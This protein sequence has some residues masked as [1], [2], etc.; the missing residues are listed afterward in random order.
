MNF[1]ETR[2]NTTGL[3]LMMCQFGDWNPIEVTP[4]H[5]TASLSYIHDVRRMSEL[6]SAIGNEEDATMWQR[7]SDFLTA[8]FHSSCRVVNNAC[9]HSQTDKTDETDEPYGGF[10]NGSHYSTGTQMST[11]AALW[12]GDMPDDGRKEELLK[13]LTADLSK[14]GLTGG[15]VFTQYMYEALVR[16][17]RTAAAVGLLLRTSFPGFGHEIYNIYEPGSTLW[18]SW[19]G[20]SMAQ[21]MGESSRNHHYQTSIN[22]FLRKYVVGLTMPPGVTGWAVVKVRPEVAG[23]PLSLSKEIPGASL[24]L[25]THRG[26]LSLYWRRFEDGTGLKIN[27]TLPG[28]ST[29]EIHFPATKSTIISLDHEVV[30]EAGSPALGGH[31]AKKKG[32]VGATFDGAFVAFSTNRGGTFVFSSSNPKA[33]A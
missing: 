21:W 19:T 20:D 6:A 32:L 12:L 5:L 16:S 28:T 2:K 15:F 10:W 8:E 9:H 14:R 31:L 18:E 27:C 7:K 24:S 30:W 26:P 13:G 4:C 22:T 29:G 33:A 17:D 1:L 11:G 25:D 3:G 23:L